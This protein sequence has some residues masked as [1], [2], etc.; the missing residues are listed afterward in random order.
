MEHSC[1]DAVKQSAHQGS[2]TKP[3]EKQDCRQASPWP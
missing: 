1:V 3:T 2:L